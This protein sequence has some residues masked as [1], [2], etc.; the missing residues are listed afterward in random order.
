MFC[1]RRQLSA[2]QSA[3]VKKKRLRRRPSR[4][5]RPSPCSWPASKVIKTPPVLETR[6]LLRRAAIQTKPTVVSQQPVFLTNA[7]LDDPVSLPALRGHSLTRSQKSGSS[8]NSPRCPQSSAPISK[9]PTPKQSHNTNS[10]T[11]PN[12]QDTTTTVQVVS[13]LSASDCLP[14]IK[15]PAAARSPAFRNPFPL[16]PCNFHTQPST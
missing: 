16:T 11:V 12:F 7:A 9:H 3:S 10:S 14:L 2:L 8:S 6:T 13:S 5:A 4:T 15:V 1:A